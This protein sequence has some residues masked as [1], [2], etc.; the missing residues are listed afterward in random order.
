MKN[1]FHLRAVLL[2]GSVLLTVACGSNIPSSSSNDPMNMAGN[3][4]ITTVSTKGQGTVSG[5]ANVTQ[6]GQ[7]IGTNGTTTLTAV[8]GSITVSQSGTSLTGTITNSIKA[9]SYNFTGTLSGGNITITGSAPCS[10]FSGSPVVTSITGTITSTGMQGNYTITRGV[11][12]YYSSDAGTWTAT[13][14]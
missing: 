5:T 10:S 4:T 7:G 3:W 6:S 1:N 13:K 9:V 11:G 12:C 2:L 14:Q 8:I